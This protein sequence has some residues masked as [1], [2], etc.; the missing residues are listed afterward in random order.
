M[1]ALF[2]RENTTM[3]WGHRWAVVI[4]LA[5]LAALA[6]ARTAQGREEWYRG[7]D[8]EP[9]AQADLIL[10]ARVAE[11]GEQKMVYGGKTERVSVQL[12]FTPVRTLKGVFTRDALLLTT[13]D[14]GGFDEPSSI[15][16]GQLRLLLLGRNGRGYANANRRGTLDQSVPPL[17]DQNDP[18]LDT[19]KVLIAVGQQHD[20]EKRVALLVDGLR[21]AK[22]ASA[23][24][25]L[26]ALSRRRLLAAQT[27]GAPAAVMSHLADDSPAVREAAAGELR[28]LLAIDYLDQKGLRESAVSALAELLGRDDL[29]LDVRLTAL[30]GLGAAGAPALANAAS[31]AQLKI[32]RPRD[33]FAERGAVLSAVGELKAVAQRGAV[34]ALLEALPLDAPSDVQ[35]AAGLALVRLDSAPAQKQLLSRLRKKSALGIDVTSD[36]ILLA[37]LPKESAAAALLDVNKLDLLHGEKLAFAQVAAKAADP[38]LV[39]ALAAMLN[40]RRPDLRWQAIDALRKIDT[41]AA[42]N[43]VLPHLK[44]EEDLGRKLV[45]A[46]FLGRHGLRDGYPYAMEHLSEPG[47]VEEAVAALAAIRDPRTV[48]VLRDILKTSND[49]TWNSAAIRALGA[50]GEKEFAPQFLEIVQD[51]KDPLAPAALIALGDLGETKALPKV[52]E[53]LVSRNEHIALTSARAAGKL[54]ALPGVKADELRD[55]LA[56]LFADPDAG[57]GLRRVA[58][59]TLVKVNDPRLDKALRTAVRD[60]SLE[61]TALLARTEQLLAERKVKLAG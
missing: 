58:L 59:E 35:W 44:E 48:P 24:P 18:L 25:L 27:K 16:K 34:A 46:A 12:T 53:G 40:P 8:L 15:E 39:P 61:H 56:V 20:R 19:V 29:P 4:G 30:Q 38:R 23:V 5:L 52:R 45:L 22:G 33:T 9:A 21:G 31:A 10:V 60:A 57:E 47:L 6:G 14:L 7:L 2:F 49:T 43:A 51:L 1:A 42:A 54:L 36:T 13:D 17:V 55:Q 28:A 11:I 3:K 50:L 26:I 41:D 37:E 32:D